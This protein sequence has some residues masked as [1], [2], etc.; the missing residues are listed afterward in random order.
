LSAYGADGG[1]TLLAG[2]WHTCKHG[3]HHDDAGAGEECKQTSRAES[4]DKYRRHEK[5]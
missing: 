5:R 1:Y 3:K 2:G 4:Y